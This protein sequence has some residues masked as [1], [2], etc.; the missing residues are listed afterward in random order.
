MLVTLTGQHTSASGNLCFSYVGLELQTQ[1]LTLAEEALYQI[2][3]PSISVFK[4]PPVT[5]EGS[6]AVRG[7]T[8][9]RLGCGVGVWKRIAK[10]LNAIM[11][12]E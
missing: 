5:G 6:G 4:D 9:L 10:G 12:I 2:L 11:A 8:D 3:V 1:F 7:D